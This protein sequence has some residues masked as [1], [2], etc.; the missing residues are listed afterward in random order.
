[1][2]LGVH[3]GKVAVSL[4]R[5]MTGGVAGGSPAEGGVGT[6]KCD[7]GGRLSPSLFPSIF[8]VGTAGV[9][10]APNLNSKFEFLKKT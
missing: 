1:M 5:M 3:G 8:V 9:S 10:C 2:C 6:T 4:S 7:A